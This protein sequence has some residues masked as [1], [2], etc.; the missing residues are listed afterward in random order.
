MGVIV[1]S[2]YKCSAVYTLANEGV[3]F[4]M[5]EKRYV[6]SPPGCSRPSVRG[7]SEGSQRS[8]VKTGRPRKGTLRRECAGGK[9][10]KEGKQRKK[11][12]EK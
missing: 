7:S 11:E 3:N 6:Q 4:D 2:K 12:Q 8:R 1:C 10:T 9:G 5:R